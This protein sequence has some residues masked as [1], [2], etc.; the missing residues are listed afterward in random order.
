MLNSFWWGSNRGSGKG[1]N[2]LSWEKLTMRKEYGGMGFRHVYGFNLALLGKQGWKLATNHDTIVD[3]VFKA[4][5]FPRGNFLGANLGHNPSFIWRSIHAS[6][7]VV[8]GGL[9]WRVGDGRNI[10]VW[11][12]AW[13]RDHTNSYVTSSIIPGMESMCV[14]D[15]IHPND[16]EWKRGMIE[17][18]FNERDAATILEIPLFDEVKEDG[19]TWKFNSHGEYSVKSAYYYIME[20]L[21]DNEAFRVEGNWLSIWKLRIPQKVKVFLWRM[22]RGCLPTREKLQQKGVHCSNRCVHCQNNFENE[23]HIFVGCRKAQEIWEEADLWSIIDGLIDMADGFVSL[24]F[25][26]L[27]RLSQVQLCNFVMGLWCIWKRR[28]EKL[29]EDIEHRPSISFQI[30]RDY[31]FQWKQVHSRGGTRHNNDDVG[32]V[33]Q[34]AETAEANFGVYA[35]DSSRF[36]AGRR[37]QQRHPAGAAAATDTQQQTVMNNHVWTAPEQGAFKCNVDAAIFKDRNCYGAGMCI[38]D[39]RGN[40][41]RAQTMWR[42]G[43]PLPHEAE[44]WSLKE[45]LHWIENLGYTNVSIELDCKLVVDGVV[46]NPNSQTEFGAILSVCKA[47][48]SL[49]QNLRISFIRR[50]A[51]NVAHLLARAS[52]SFASHQEFDYIPSCIVNVLM[53]ERS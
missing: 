19:Y 15:L 32:S 24:F 49:L 52:L 20:N 42:K 1:I 39:Y 44:A 5:Y 3:R 22:A 31:L 33:L 37:G 12:D 29:W 25:Q 50:Q 26:L 27:Q 51:N 9:R 13:L 40:F 38:R 14:N 17:E 7:V 43:S 18:M 48:L 23:W 34:L 2:W 28:N 21:I 45:A 10:N 47:M 11:H 46:G 16:K 41:I 8:K 6:Q 30:A 36:G 35:G 4:R 53:N